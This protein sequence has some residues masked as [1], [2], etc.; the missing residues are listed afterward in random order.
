[1]GRVETVPVAGTCRAEIHCL[2]ATRHYAVGRKFALT[3]DGAWND[4]LCQRAGDDLFNGGS[5]KGIGGDG[6][7]LGVT[8]TSALTLPQSFAPNRK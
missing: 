5:G 8:V 2:H 6:L 7:F 3:A 4:R 1:M